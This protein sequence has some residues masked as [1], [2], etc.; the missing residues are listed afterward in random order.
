ML[1]PS[2]ASK[3]DEVKLGFA[4]SLAVRMRSETANGDADKNRNA[5]ESV[6]RTPTRSRS[7][8]MTAKS[9]DARR[10]LFPR[11]LINDVPRNRRVSSDRCRA[12]LRCVGSTQSIVK[13]CYI[14][15]YAFL[16]GLF[17]APRLSLVNLRSESAFSIHYLRLHL[18]GTWSIGSY[19]C[20]WVSN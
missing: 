1:I 5:D 2:G 19:E 7:A 13:E 15:K 11:P 6:E 3:C 4:L 10:R 12:H 9:P 17:S 14:T 20:C 16:V 18:L 8:T